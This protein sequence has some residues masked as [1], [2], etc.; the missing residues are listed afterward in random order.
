MYI[1]TAAK[2]HNKGRREQSVNF[3][4][5]KK[6]LLYKTH[7][8]TFLSTLSRLRAM[9]LNRPYHTSPAIIALEIIYE[10]IT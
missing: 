9:L 6:T 1:Y 8:I 5:K 3:I 4:S 2:I 7:F 10:H